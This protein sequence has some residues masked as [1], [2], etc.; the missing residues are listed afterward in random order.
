M[1]VLEALLD[2]EELP[3]GL[4][5]GELAAEVARVARR[6]PVL[7]S[8]L[9]H[10]LDDRAALEQLLVRNPIAA[11]AAGKGT[12]GV[13]HF[14]FENGRFATRFDA[15]TPEEREGLQQL[16]RELVDWRLAE[17]LD[18]RRPDSG[19]DAFRCK[20]S[21]ASGRTALSPRARRP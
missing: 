14:T 5:V 1:L 16:V 4:E 15:A 3:G 17:Y 18:R 12:G 6:S 13:P 8:E 9:R 19:G 2:R 10:E 7:A 11:W 20:V 21:H